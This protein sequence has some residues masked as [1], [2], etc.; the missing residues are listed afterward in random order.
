M[1][2]KDIYVFL[3]IDGVLNAP[4][5]KNIVYN[6]IEVNKLNMFIRFVNE[7]DANVVI[8]SD[9]RLYKEEVYSIKL[10]LSKCKNV[11]ILSDKRFFRHRGQE[12]E[13]YIRENNIYNFVIF[14]DVDDGISQI[15]N[16][17][18]KFILVNYLS[19]LKEE[20]VIKAKKIVNY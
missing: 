11:D 13:H 1:N 6:M 14:D 12:I 20:D 3:D 15:E 17:K 16:L 5:D 8:T 7:V 9:R 19:G 18:D 10:A 4:G 2:F